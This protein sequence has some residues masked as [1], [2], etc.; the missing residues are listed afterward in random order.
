MFWGDIVVKHPD[1][2]TRLPKDSICLNW[3]YSPDVTEDSTRLLAQAGAVQYVC[4]GVSGWNRIMNRIPDSYQ[5]ITRM[6]AYGRRYGAV[7]LLNTDW[8]DYGHINDP[9]FSLPGMIMGAHAGW[10]EEELPFD[11]ICGDISLL[12]W[13]DGSGRTVGLLAGLQGLDVCS[14]WHLVQYREHVLGRADEGHGDTLAGLDA[15]AVEAA[16]RQA[17]EIARELTKAS[18]GMAPE[19]RRELQGWQIACEGVRVWNQTGLAVCRRQQDAALAERLERWLYHYEQLWQQVSKPSELWRIREM[20]R[21][22]AARL[23]TA[24]ACS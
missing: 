13:Q 3:G 8:G 4:P 22:Y 10:S 23:R 18:A 14:W 15:A 19:A 6:A 17:A 11:A 1:A 5:N 9:R 7:G 2:L 24:G 16:D 12:V 21:W 20:V